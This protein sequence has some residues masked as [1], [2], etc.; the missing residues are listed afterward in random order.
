MIK[1]FERLLFVLA[2]GIRGYI[3]VVRLR[4]LIE[5]QE[6]E[7]AEAGFVCVAAISIAQ[8][9]FEAVNYVSYNLSVSS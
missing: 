3:N 7:P 8:H 9:F 1:L 2:N 5:N 6:F 4:G